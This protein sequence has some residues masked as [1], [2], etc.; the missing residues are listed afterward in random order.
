V[1][2]FYDVL[3]DEV[4][5]TIEGGDTSAQPPLDPLLKVLN[6]KPEDYEDLKAFLGSLSAA[7][8]DRARPESVPSGL[9]PGGG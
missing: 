8:Y 4:S 6:V 3:M 5:E 2:V 1:L 9:R 7:E